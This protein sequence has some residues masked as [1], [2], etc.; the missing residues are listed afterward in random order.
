[1]SKRLRDDEAAIASLQ[2]EVQ[3]L[4]KRVITPTKTLRLINRQQQQPYRFAQPQPIF[5]VNT[6]PINTPMDIAEGERQAA[7]QSLPGYYAIPPPPPLS[8]YGSRAYQR[9]KRV[10]ANSKNAAI[11]YGKALLKKKSKASLARAR[12][13]MK[14]GGTAI[15]KKTLIKAAAKGS[16]RLFYKDLITWT[17]ARL[18]KALRLEPN[19]VLASCLAKRYSK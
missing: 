15:P 13:S 17:K 9:V 14:K 5:N 6:A 11:S 2:S 1:M 3:N 12:T 16:K 10:A 19:S 7:M 4:K 8:T 18:I